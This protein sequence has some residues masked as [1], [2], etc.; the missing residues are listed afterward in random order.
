MI[1]DIRFMNIYSANLNL[2]VSF[3]ALMAEKNVTRAARRLGLSQSAVSNA[4]A[5]LREMFDDPLFTRTR[6][7]IEPTRRAVELAPVIRGGLS[8]LDVALGRPSAFEPGTSDRSFV[9]ATDDYVE[10][11]VLPRLMK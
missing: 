1:S 7:G 6:Y 5:Q 2:L 10:Y 3:D 11:V 4:L 9:I 8:Q